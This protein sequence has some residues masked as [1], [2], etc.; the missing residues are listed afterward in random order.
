MRDDHRVRKTDL[1]TRLTAD[2]GVAE[3]TGSPFVSL[4]DLSHEPRSIASSSSLVTT[5][6]VSQ[7]VIHLDTFLSHYHTS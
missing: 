5:L 1:Y 6:R 2:N 7:S 4:S 3:T